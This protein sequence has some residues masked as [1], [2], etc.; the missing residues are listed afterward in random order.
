MKKVKVKTMNGDSLDHFLDCEVSLYNLEVL[1]VQKET[2]GDWFWGYATNY[3][4]T[5]KEDEEYTRP[6]RA[7]HEREVAEAMKKYEHLK[8]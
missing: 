6:L 4:V 3:T 5:Y 2:T 7:K 1:N 8:K